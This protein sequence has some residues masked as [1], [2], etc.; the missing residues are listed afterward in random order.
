MAVPWEKQATFVNPFAAGTL[1]RMHAMNK[2]ISSCRIFYNDKDTRE[3]L[4]KQCFIAVAT[5]VYCCCIRT[6]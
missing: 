6:I 4:I 3:Y 1:K 5:I 2:F